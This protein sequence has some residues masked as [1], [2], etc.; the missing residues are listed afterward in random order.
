MDE[1]VEVRENHE[2]GDEDYYSEEDWRR[3]G[4]F[5]TLR[6]M[7][8]RKTE[9]TEH[10]GDGH[11]EE[12]GLILPMI[13]FDEAT[14]PFRSRYNPTRQ[15]GQVSQVGHQGIC[16]FVR[17]D[18]VLS[19]IYCGAKTHLLAPVPDVNNIGEAAVLRNINAL[20]LSSKKSPWRLVVT[21]RFYT[22]VK[23]TLDLLHRRMYLTGI[24]STK[25]SEWTKEITIKKEMKTVN[26]RQ[27]S[28][29]SQG[30]IK[31]AQNKQLPQITAAV[32]VWMDRTPRYS[33]QLCYKTRRYYK[34]LFFGLLDMGLVN[35]FIVYRVYK[36]RHDMRSQPGKRPTKHYVFF[37]T[38]MAQLLAVDS[39]EIY[40][41][42]E[43]CF[44][45][46]EE[47]TQH[48]ATPATVTIGSHYLD[49][50]SAM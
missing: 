26:G 37:E 22:S 18:C 45:L 33:V 20:C 41:A 16:R 5:E 39:T 34:A 13:S 25:R 50:N 23:L 28:V 35:V 27:F 30:T 2:D 17:G 24:I 31:L 12:A 14:L 40:E 10:E 48:H 15:E 42:I 49:E 6:T 8:A 43:S 36:D 19:E 38:V 4:R 32:W 7:L 44:P 1:D 46:H 9:T 3:I 21:D 11:N 29:P 47:P